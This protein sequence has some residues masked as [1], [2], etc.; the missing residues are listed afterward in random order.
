MDADTLF[1]NVVYTVL[2]TVT[3][4]TDSEYYMEGLNDAESGF[5]LLSTAFEVLADKEYGYYLEKGE[6][7]YSYI[8]PPFS[9]ALFFTESDPDFESDR[10][11][12]IKVEL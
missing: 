12:M 11:Q 3:G 1:E 2:A 9:F 10:D 4:L 5:E 7:Y 6:S 8:M